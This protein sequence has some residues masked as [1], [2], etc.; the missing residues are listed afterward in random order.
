MKTF[1]GA[2]AIVRHCVSDHPDE[3]VS[4][5]WPLLNDKCPGINDIERSRQ[6]AR[7]T[8]KE[9]EGRHGQRG[10]KMEKEREGERDKRRGEG[11]ET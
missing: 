9:G 3:Y 5:L 11:E 4:L 1:D 2:D 8:V 6:D 7:E 10:E